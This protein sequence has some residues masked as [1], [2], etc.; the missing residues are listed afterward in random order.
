MLDFVEEALN[1]VA[2]LIDEPI[3]LTGFDA[4]AT[5]W[6]DRRQTPCL[7]GLDEFIAV[8]VGEVDRAVEALIGEDA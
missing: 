6:N 1:Q 8:V 5:G 7:N 4:V 3:H 2:L